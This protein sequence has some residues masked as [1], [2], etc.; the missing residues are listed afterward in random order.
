MTIACVL[1]YRLYIYIITYIYVDIHVLIF[2][3]II[4]Y[5]FLNTHPLNPGPATVPDGYAT[6]LSRG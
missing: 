5:N 4:L 6:N 2:Q 1:N 3:K